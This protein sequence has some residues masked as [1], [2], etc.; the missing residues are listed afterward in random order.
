[1]TSTTSQNSILA[2]QRDIPR[3]GPIPL[4]TLRPL[5]VSPFLAAYYVRH[6][7]LER[8]GR[9]LYAFPNDQLQLGPCL[10]H[11]QE[12]CAGFHVGGKT[13]LAWRGVRHYL[14]PRQPLVLWGRHRFRLPTWFADR[15]PAQYRYTALFSDAITE[16]DA[17]GVLPEEDKA[18]VL[19]SEP[20][21]ALLELLSDVGVSESLDET[22]KL[23]ES[24]RNVRTDV[25]ARLLTHCTSVKT[26]KLA[27]LLATD[28][29]LPWAQAVAD[30]PLNRGKGRWVRRLSDG[31]TLIL[32]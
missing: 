20:E 26:V 2:V 5:G 30:L 29:A 11:L 25:L 4:E 18:R 17:V 31:S 13:A 28:L 14:G 21:R 16:K 1:V 19:V 24:T 9:G 10:R 3:G 22:R 32:K 7:W 23:V 27:T 12:R 8:L 6:G 15:F